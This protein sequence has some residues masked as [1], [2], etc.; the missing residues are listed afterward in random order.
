MKVLHMASLNRASA[1]LGVVQQMEWEQLA[2]REA[3]LDWDVELWTTEAAQ[4]GSVLRQVPRGMTGF[5]G[6]RYHFHRRLRAAARKY[7]RIVI[8]HAPLD[9]F[10]L[11]IPEWVRCKTWYVFHTKTGNY[12]TARG[13]R[14]GKAFAWFDRQFTRCAIGNSA[15]I[16]GVTDE[17][18]DYERDRIQCHLAKSATYPN[19]IFLEDWYSKLPDRR[20][21]PIKI[22]FIASRFYNWNGL[23]KLLLSILNTTTD[24]LWELHLVGQVMPHHIDFIE[25]NGLANQVHI[26][27]VLD[28]KAIKELMASMDVSLGAFALEQ[29]SAT[30]ACTLKVRQSLG[31]GI[32]VYAGHDDVGV[33]FR[34]D[35]FQRGGADWGAVL[36]FAVES[37]G[38]SRD[39]VRSAAREGIDKVA[40][41]SELNKA[42]TK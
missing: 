30:T 14:L 20:G 2:A 26:H 17:L 13:K 28:E 21:G 35:C 31:L 5:F 42:I 9:P 10:S 15:G 23:E 8:R 24:H 16:I 41:L 4:L 11:F 3:G 39:R 36:S 19:G 12:L 38:W 27:G 34:P 22:I 18:V 25:E 40:L 6:R 29:V 7:D 32:P 1:N 33:R 37:R